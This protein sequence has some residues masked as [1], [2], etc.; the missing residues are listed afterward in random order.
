VRAP[1]LRTAAEAFLRTGDVDAAAFEPSVF[2]AYVASPDGLPDTDLQRADQVLAM[3][4]GRLAAGKADAT[5]RAWLA[6]LAPYST[7]VVID[8]DVRPEIK[9]TAPP[10]TYEPGE[11]AGRAYA[12]SLVDGKFVCAAT[13][14]A[15]NTPSEAEP[16]FLDGVGRAPDARERLHRELEIGIRRSLAANLKAIEP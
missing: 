9:Q 15:R 14:R 3:I 8:K 2:Q 6:G 12:L 7:M 5:D 11:V 13:I 1:D 4:D 10:V 16:K